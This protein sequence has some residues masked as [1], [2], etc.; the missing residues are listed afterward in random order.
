MGSVTF[1][2]L[3]FQPLLPLRRALPQGHGAPC[4]G[5][6]GPSRPSALSLRPCIEGPLQSLFFLP[7]REP[8]VHSGA[9]SEV[10][11]TASG[12]RDT[13][14]LGLAGPAQPVL[15]EHGLLCWALSGSS[16]MERECFFCLLY[17]CFYVM[18]HGSVVFSSRTGGASGLNQGP[19]A[20]DLRTH[21]TICALGGSVGKSAQVPVTGRGL[22][23]GCRA[24]SRPHPAVLRDGPEA[25]LAGWRSSPSSFLILP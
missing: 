16:D 24:E 20:L 22:G 13:K 15:R 7:L 5:L 9:H 4:P 17:A 18:S 10:H 6:A 19:L 11:C 14:D 12:P 2:P 8:R 23:I 25:R 1:L 21:G 3:L